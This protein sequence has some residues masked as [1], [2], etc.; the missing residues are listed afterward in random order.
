MEYVDPLN[1]LMAELMLVAPIQPQPGNDRSS[2]VTMRSVLT[3]TA[4]ADETQVP[5][6]GR[7]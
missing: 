1:A 5:R 6:T 2:R 4:D 3:A 7:P